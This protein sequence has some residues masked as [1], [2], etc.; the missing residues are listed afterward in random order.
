MNHDK[1]FFEKQMEKI[2]NVNPAVDHP[3]HYQG[4][5]EVIDI[6]EQATEGIDGRVAFSLGNVIK[7]IMRHQHKGGL[8]DLKKA[9]WYLDRAIELEGK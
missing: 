8:E 4:K 1:Q 9:R 3:S 7:Y 6:I 5:T 2:A